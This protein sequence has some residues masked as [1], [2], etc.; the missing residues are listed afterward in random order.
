VDEYI[1][2]LSFFTKKA[3]GIS[4]EGEEGISVRAEI[5]RELIYN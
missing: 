4:L 5:R 3:L 2:R 1:S